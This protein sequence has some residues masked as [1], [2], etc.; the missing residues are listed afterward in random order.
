M[1]MWR[2]RA[3]PRGIR[4]AAA[5]SC[6]HLGNS[7]PVCRGNLPAQVPNHCPY[8]EV[9]LEP[10][11]GG[12]YAPSFP[13]IKPGQC[14]LSLDF[15]QQPP[16]GCP[17]R[18]HGKKNP[19]HRKQGKPST[20]EYAKYE[21]SWHVDAADGGTLL[22]G[23]MPGDVDLLDPRLAVRDGV[24]RLVVVAEDPRVRPAIAFRWQ[25]N[26]FAELEDMEIPNRFGY[27]LVLDPDAA[28]VA[29]V[30]TVG[31]NDGAELIAPVAHPSIAPLGRQ[32]VLELRV[33]GPTFQAWVNGTYVAAA[34]DAVGGFGR[35]GIHV[36]SG[37][38]ERPGPRDCSFRVLMQG[39]DV[40]TVTA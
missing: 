15:S 30:R 27:R 11:P 21:Y 10:A 2:A 33:H 26:R 8:C 29:L 1:S 12:G 6:C 19:L 18:D 16:L 14:L 39:F 17:S 40:W 35:V 20:Y 36:G 9:R 32:N 38:S 3:D 25:T 5:L 28:T 23:Y 24:V 34:H 7:C 22:S 13:A 37:Y 4:R 31:D